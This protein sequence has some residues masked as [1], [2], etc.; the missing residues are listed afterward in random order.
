ME[1]SF[2]TSGNAKYLGHKIQATFLMLIHG[3]VGRNNFLNIYSLEWVDQSGLKY[4][5]AVSWPSCTIHVYKFNVSCYNRYD[6]IL[7]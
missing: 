4:V 5:G 6:V 3:N 1:N 7:T 2:Q